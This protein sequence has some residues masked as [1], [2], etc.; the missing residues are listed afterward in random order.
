MTL[1]DFILWLS[2]Q[3]PEARYTAGDPDCCLFAAWAKPRGLLS[4]VT[5]GYTQH[6]GRIEPIFEDD[7]PREALSYLAQGS[8]LTERG[9]TFGAALGR[10]VEVMTAD[11]VPKHW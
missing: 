9:Q 11:S 7:F 4:A 1:S 2:T 3:N 10:A 6:H 5:W 8:H